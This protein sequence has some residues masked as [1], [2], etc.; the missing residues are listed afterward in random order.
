MWKICIP[1][2]LLLLLLPA[3][4]EGSSS[5]LSA[6]SGRINVVSSNLST[7][8]SSGQIKFGQHYNFRNWGSARYYCRW[9]GTDLATIG[10]DDVYDFSNGYGWIGVYR[11][12]SQSVWKW[13]KGD[14][15]VGFT[16]WAKGKQSERVIE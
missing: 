11:Q 2:P 9:K 3:V 8:V 15:E 14:Q 16:N 10:K 5:S 4:G 1:V 12:D 13:S 7:A 6:S